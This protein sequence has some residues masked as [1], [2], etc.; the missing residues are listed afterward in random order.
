MSSEV[1]QFYD[2]LAE[3]FHLIFDDWDRAIA[4]QAGVLDALIRTRCGHECSLGH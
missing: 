2:S 3:A 1:E 4:R